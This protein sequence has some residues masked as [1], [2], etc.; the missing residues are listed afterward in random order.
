MSFCKP[1]EYDHL[2]NKAINTFKELLADPSNVQDEVY[3]VIVGDAKKT[4]SQVRWQRDVREKLTQPNEYYSK[5]RAR[6]D[7]HSVKKKKIGTKDEKGRCTAMSIH[8]MEAVSTAHQC[9][10]TL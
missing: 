4:L 10:S 3:I 8:K 6:D 5:S 1:G 9:T 7:R 2:A